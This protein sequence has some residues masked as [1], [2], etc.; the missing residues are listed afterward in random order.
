M[1]KGIPAL[2][3]KYLVSSPHFGSSVH[4]PRRCFL[5]HSQLLQP[6]LYYVLIC[7]HLLFNLQP[8]LPCV[9]DP[10]QPNFHGA[11]PR[12][13][14]CLP[15]PPPIPTFWC[16]RYLRANQPLN[17]LLVPLVHDPV[18]K[19]KSENYLPRSSLVSQFKSAE[20]FCPCLPS[21]S[22]S[23]SS[24]SLSWTSSYSAHSLRPSPR[25]LYSFS[26]NP[27]ASSRGSRVS[28]CRVWPGFVKTHRLG[29]ALLTRPRE[30]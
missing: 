15:Q 17:T 23:S 5:L 27:G 1:L 26:W 3:V 8:Y 24:P 19:L 21:F 4:R 11:A 18:N 14:G 29:A 30:Y 25:P 13:S 10:C 7:F 20:K 9:S 12:Q 6:S 2:R 22:S 16:R 28:S